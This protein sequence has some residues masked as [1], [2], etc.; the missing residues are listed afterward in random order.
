MT[1]AQHWI[2]ALH[3]QPHPEGGFYRE[4]Y[5]SS[6][7]IPRSALPSRYVGERSL[8]TSIYFLLRAGEC[9]R[10]HRLQSDE[11]WYYHAGGSAII[12][13]FLEDGSYHPFPIGA[14]ASPQVVI[15]RG[16][17]FGATVQT[18]H[19]ILVGC[20]VFPGFDFADFELANPSELLA[21]YP[22][23]QEIIRSLTQGT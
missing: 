9:S 16:R 19:Y 15:P 20:A 11:I 1:T 5:R 10:L 22:A 7:S 4:V 14:E 8:G 6:E 3:L 12:H 17:W 23:Q 18:G 21:R 2:E 13:Q